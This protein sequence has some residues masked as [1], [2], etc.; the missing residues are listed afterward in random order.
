[1]GGRIWYRG[2]DTPDGKGEEYDEDNCR[3]IRDL[4]RAS[5]RSADDAKFSYNMADIDRISEPLGVIWKLVKD[6]PFGPSAKYDGFKWD[7]KKYEVSV[8]KEKREKYLEDLTKW[9]ERKTHTL[10]DVHSLYGKLLHVS[11][12]APEGHAYL[13]EFEKMAATGSANPLADRHAPRK[14]MPDDIKWWKALLSQRHVVRPIP[15][16]CELVELHAFSDASS[17]V[18]IGIIIRGRWRAWRLIPGWKRGNCNIGW[19]EAV[20]FKLLARAVGA[21]ASAGEHYKLFGDN[22]GVV[23]G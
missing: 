21:Y 23:E 22:Q 17:E 18:G 13:T 8:P 6:S 15:G 9:E 14:R 10:E 1:L 4:S 3:P 5:V 7:L 16:L 20:G 11:L 2:A 12:I 19:A